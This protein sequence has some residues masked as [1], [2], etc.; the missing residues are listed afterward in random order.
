MTESIPSYPLQWPQGRTRTEY[1]SRSKFGERSIDGATKIL[2]H[3]VQLLRGS[4]LVLSTNLKRRPDGMPYSNQAQPKDQGVAVYF[5]LK[6]RQMCFSCDRWDRI[7]DNIYAIAMTVE[8]LRGIERWGSGQMVEQAFTG[9]TALP[10]PK[11]LDWRAVLGLQGENFSTA[12]IQ[13]A[14][15]R[16]AGVRHPDTG[17]TDAAFTELVAARREALDW[18]RGRS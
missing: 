3:Q 9:F 11:P 12:D 14:Y 7:Q 6:N 18:I 17:G 2:V 4:Q 8:A 1:P 5:T 16:E 10:A 15:R 13:C